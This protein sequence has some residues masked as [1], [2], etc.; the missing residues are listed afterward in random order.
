MYNLSKLSS[1]S[2]SFLSQVVG[3]G[4][5]RSSLMAIAVARMLS[6]EFTIPSSPVEDVDQEYRN[7]SQLKAAKDVSTLNELFPI[8]T[9]YT[10]ALCRNFYKFRYNSTHP[11]LTVFS[12]REDKTLID[13]FGLNRV[14]DE[15]TLEAIS[16]NGKDL[17]FYTNG[18]RRILVD[19]TEADKVKE[20]IAVSY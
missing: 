2:Q 11:E 10:M 14:F 18:L 4:R 12:F 5:S 16:C 8:D 9:E 7:I 15:K 13:F 17:A 20:P 3:T 6:A 19:I 1:E